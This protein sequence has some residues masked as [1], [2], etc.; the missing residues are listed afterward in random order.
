MATKID[1]EAC[2]TAY[3]LVR[4]DGSAVIWVTFKYDG[5]TIVP[6]EQ[7][8]DYQEFIQQCT[9]LFRQE[10]KVSTAL[11]RDPRC[12]RNAFNVWHHLGVCLE[13][14]PGTQRGER[15][16]GGSEGGNQ[17]DLVEV[18]VELWVDDVRLFA[19]VRFTTGDA[20]SKRSKFALITWIGEN[21]S[22]LQRAKT[23]TDKTLVKEVVQNFAK[24]FVISDRKELEED[25]IKTE[26]KKAGGANYDAQAE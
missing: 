25:F 26:L 17:A 20:M 13:G 18:K 21:V 2:R 1:K 6:G 23:G 10:E 3:N 5:S 8:A 22:G 12:S 15:E 7:G 24:E 11:N 4:D 9:G 16:Y 19:F 14:L